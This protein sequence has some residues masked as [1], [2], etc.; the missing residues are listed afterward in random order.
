MVRLLLTEHLV[1]KRLYKII[2]LFL[3]I[4]FI[5][6]YFT[7]QSIN[8]SFPSEDNTE[9]VALSPKLLNEVYQG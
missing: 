1:M 3:I 5:G 6:I 9:T 2:I 8:N 7:I 4:F